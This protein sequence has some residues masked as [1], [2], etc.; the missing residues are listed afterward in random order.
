MCDDNVPLCG[1]AN[2]ADEWKKCTLLSAVNTALI[3]D[4]AKE[5]FEKLT[6]ECKKC[7][8][9]KWVISPGKK[10]LVSD[11]TTSSVT[12]YVDRTSCLKFCQGNS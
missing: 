11:E 6:S 9:N 7:E 5:G 12:E 10:F 8:W 3:Y 1:G 4:A 2:Y